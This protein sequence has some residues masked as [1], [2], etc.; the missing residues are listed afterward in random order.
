M[1]DQKRALNLFEAGGPA[2]ARWASAFAKA[3]ADRMEGWFRTSRNQKE[4]PAGEGR[5][6]RHQELGST[7]I[8]LAGGTS[9]SPF[10]R[11]KQGEI[12]RRRARVL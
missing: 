10:Q 11:E 3:S 5:A 12:M 6:R 9:G 2:V 7:D 1:S 4:R 8:F